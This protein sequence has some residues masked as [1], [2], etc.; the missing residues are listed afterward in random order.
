MT[1]HEEKVRELEE[2]VRLLKQASDRGGADDEAAKD[3]D[4][5]LKSLRTSSTSEAKRLKRNA[6]N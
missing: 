2:Q 6:K 1:E 3:S 5:K 4:E